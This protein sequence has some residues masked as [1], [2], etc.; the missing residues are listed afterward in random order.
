[1]Y[2]TSSEAEEYWRPYIG[3][4]SILIRRIPQHI[5]QVLQGHIDTLCYWVA[6]KPGRQLNFIRLWDIIE[7]EGDLR[8]SL[9]LLNTLLEKTFCVSFQS[10]CGFC[11][12]LFGP[13]WRWVR[14]PGSP[15]CS[16]QCH[17]GIK[18]HAKRPEAARQV[19]QGW[20][21]FQDQMSEKLQMSEALRQYFK[22]EFGLDTSR[23]G[24]KAMMA[25]GNLLAEP[26]LKERM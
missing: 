20:V 14:D 9:E 12:S 21:R 7:E 15:A 19:Q 2:I 16:P 3:Q 22:D 6:S 24:L 1:M 23:N 13:D 26:C 8:Q 10:L 17:A 4:A 18:Q 11:D 25:K 5:M